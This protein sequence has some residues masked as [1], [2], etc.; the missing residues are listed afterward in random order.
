MK[1][2]ERILLNTILCLVMVAGMGSLYLLN[3]QGVEAEHATPTPTQETAQVEDASQKS[4]IISR[5][6][7]ARLK[8]N[9]TKNRSKSNQETTPTEKG[10]RDSI[11]ISPISN[12]IHALKNHEIFK[13]TTLKTRSKTVADTLPQQPHS[14]LVR[15]DKILEN[16]K[17]F[18]ATKRPKA[19]RQTISPSR[20]A[21]HHLVNP[22]EDLANA[23]LLPHYAP[24][25]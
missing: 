21:I 24:P 20:E 16:L 12:N 2:D 8:L 17:H 15:A 7:R 9:P 1:S 14:S 10:N 6:V 11:E 23:A 13:T 19:T 3:L 18:G 4:R 25:D 5:A 22:I